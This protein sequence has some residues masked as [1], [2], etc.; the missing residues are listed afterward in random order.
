MHTTS[1]IIEQLR[2]IKSNLMEKYP[3]ESLALFGSYARDDQKAGSDVD[4]LIDFNGRIGIRFIDLADELEAHLGL[5]VDLVSRK[6]VKEGYL[7]AIRDE[8][9]YV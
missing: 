5:K 9:I 7:N 8:L 3:I 2:A 6:G 1:H 4:L